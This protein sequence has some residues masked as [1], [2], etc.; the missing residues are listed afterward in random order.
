MS[1]TKIE[2]A[3]FVV[4]HS[5]TTPLRNLVGIG[6]FAER[7]GVTYSTISAYRSRGRL[8]EPAAMLGRTPVWTRRQLNDWSRTQPGSSRAAAPAPAAVG[9]A[10]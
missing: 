4:A 9:A 7:I 3:Q 10:L 5:E 2:D 1:H 6:D 8:P